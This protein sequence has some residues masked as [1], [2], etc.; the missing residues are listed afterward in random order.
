MADIGTQ[1]IDGQTLELPPVVLGTLGRDATKKT[2][3][4]YG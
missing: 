3:L 4:V 2:L 1:Q